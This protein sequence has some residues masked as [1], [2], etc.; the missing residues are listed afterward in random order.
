MS[1]TET[2]NKIKFVLDGKVVTV[3]FNN[4]MKPTVTL[5]N[6]LRSLPGHKGVKEGCAE[7][8][9]GACTVVIAEPENGKMK[10]KA[11]NS[12]L[13]FL[14]MI[15]GKQVITVENLAETANNN[16]ILHPVQKAVVESDGTQ[17][18]F[19]T[20][21]VVMSLFGLYK[22]S[23]NPSRKEIEES[24]TG[25]LCRCTGYQPILNAG[26]T[27]PE[28]RSDKFYKDE[29]EIMEMLNQINSTSGSIRLITDK[30][31]YFKP[32]IVNELLILKSKYPDAEIISG[33]TDIALKQTKKFE[34]IE[35]IIDISAIDSLKSISEEKSFYVIGAGATLEE[36]RNYFQNRLPV[37]SD[38]LGVFA[39]KQIR[40]LATMGGN[41]ATA[42][43][44]SDTIPLLFALNAWVTVVG[45]DKEKT[46]P[47][48]KF[49]AGYRK[50]LLESDEIIRDIVIPKP[51]NNSV[52]KFFKVSK[53]Q[54]VDISS[55]SAAFSIKKQNGIA[56][57]VILAY[58]GM[59]EKTVRALKTE[60]FLLNKAWSKEN[61]E[62][63]MDILKTE[64]SPLSD[65]RAGAEYRKEVAASLLMKFFNSIKNENSTSR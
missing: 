53:R 7:G 32:N 65:V 39:S 63:A 25:N 21:G 35:R 46:L 59:A 3:D 44:I 9:C 16:L 33:A 55:V 37:I 19:C 51:E 26:L 29:P 40:N 62:Q 36:I 56:K 12:C 11:V 17:C 1:G 54:D 45:K 8:D 28:D 34:L 48:E 43:P 5:L 61:I 57:D 20:P 30:Q 4:D 58:G 27:L 15:H 49:I 22:N 50:T 23:V 47:V 38:M 42:S 52:T 18:G 13:V 24:L 41:L 31:K 2:D 64:F 6:Y 10:Y 60:E 14:P